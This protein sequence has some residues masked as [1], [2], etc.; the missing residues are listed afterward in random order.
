[1]TAPTSK[2]HALAYAVAGA[3]AM[4]ATATVEADFVGPYDHSNWTFTP[5]GDGSTVT[6][7]TNL[8]L[9]GSNNGVA[10]TSTYTIAAAASGTVSFD[11]SYSSSDV[12]NWDYGG[13]YLNGVFTTLAFNSTQGGGSFSTSVGSGDTFGFWV[14]SRDGSFGPGVLDV[15]NFNGPLA[16]PEPGTL[17]LLALGAVAGSLGFRRR[18]S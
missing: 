11:W 7:T 4:G 17:G 12:A 1:M 16:I 6:S 10:G 15:S 18:R 14:H 3:A 5:A 8:T 13:F 2:K 9:I